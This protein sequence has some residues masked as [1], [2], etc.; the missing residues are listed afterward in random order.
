[1][2]TKHFTPIVALVFMTV[3]LAATTWAQSYKEVINAN[4]PAV[5]P[6]S[7]FTADAQGSLYTAV[8]NGGL[9]FC[10]FYGCGGIYEWQPGSHRQPTMVYSFSGTT[11]GAGPGGSLVFDAQ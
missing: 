11:D 3:T 8:A 7:P 10:F 4:A 6:G 1:M 9:S 2:K 5:Y